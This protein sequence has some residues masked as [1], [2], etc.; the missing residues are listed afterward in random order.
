VFRVLFAVR[1]TILSSL[2]INSY[3]SRTHPTADEPSLLRDFWPPLDA[4]GHV[5]VSSR[6]SEIVLRKVLGVDASILPVEVL[7][8]DESCDLV[9]LHSAGGWVGGWV[10]M[11]R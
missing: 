5:L 1:Y 6:A 8:V 9:V 11:N 3:P 7:P 10:G 2:F 4:K